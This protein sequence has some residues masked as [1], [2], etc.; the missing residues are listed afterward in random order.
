MILYE[1]TGNLLGIEIIEA[2]MN[3]TEGAV[4]KTNTEN[5]KALV[6]TKEIVSGGGYDNG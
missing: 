6:Q 1:I 5:R 3:M 2:V 4:W